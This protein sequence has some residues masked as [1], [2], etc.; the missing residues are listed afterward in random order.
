MGCTSRHGARLGSGCS[1]DGGPL[2]FLPAFGASPT[3]C[4]LLAMKRKLHADTF[5][6]CKGC[7]A[8]LG[9]SSRLL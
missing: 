9:T 2:S 8:A 7:L 5:N 1:P 6:L 4:T 3:P